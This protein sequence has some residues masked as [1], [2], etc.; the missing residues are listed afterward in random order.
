MKNPLPIIVIPLPTGYGRK[1]LGWNVRHGLC[2]QIGVTKAFKTKQEAMKLA[3]YVH[4][5]PPVKSALGLDIWQ[6]VTVSAF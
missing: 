4:K 2:G 5:S 6:D 1:P 3:H